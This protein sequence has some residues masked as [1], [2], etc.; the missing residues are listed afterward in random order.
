M[1]P[2][3]YKME[4]NRY[5][6][7]LIT[8]LFLPIIP[9]TVI[10]MDIDDYPIHLV[11]TIG[12]MI[13]WSIAVWLSREKMRK[14]MLAAIFALTIIPCLIEIGWFAIGKELLHNHQFWVIFDTNMQ[15]MTGFMQIVPV[16]AYLLS[17]AALVFLVFLLI[18]ALRKENAQQFA[19]KKSRI[20]LI[21]SISFLIIPIIIPAT[22]R[23]GYPINF[24]SSLKGYVV[25]LQKMNEFLTDRP[26]L[27]GKVHRTN[28]NDSNTVIVVIG[29][30]FNRNHSS[31]YGYERSTNPLLTQ[32]KDSLLIYKNVS[33]PD[34]FTQTCLNQFLTFP[35]SIKVVEN[36][37]KAPTLIEILK[38]AGFKTYWIDNQG[39]R[40]HSDTFFP[41]SYRLLASQSDYFFVN[42]NGLHDETLLPKLDSI[43]A[44]DTSKDKVIF[45]HLMGSHFPYKERVPSN[46]RL[47]FDS[48][49]TPSQFL[50][51]NEECDNYN[52]YDN[53][54][55]YNDSVV[56]QIFQRSFA[57]HGNHAVIYFADHGEEVYDN[58]RFAGRSNRYVS[59]NLYDVPFIVHLSKFYKSELVIHQENKARLLNKP[60]NTGY[61]AFTILHLCGITTA[62][63]WKK[64]SIFL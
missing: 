10:G 63:D 26:N 30:S 59:H 23:Y 36:T 12:V 40:G 21:A 1:L 34:Y 22:R 48:P 17:A 27:D 28:Y 52:M 42:P 7:L 53:S 58:F 4:K 8:S 57:L 3:Y 56:Y 13:C 61:L 35:D 60:Y 51:D 14:V 29:E 11:G 45:L 33:S 9:L 16:Y 38:S 5:S 41:T 25:D 32:I 64:Y 39:N 47:A 15:E 18:M 37:T 62:C 19:G 50:L 46:F 24:Y 20:F 49:E 31:L 54:I 2:L 6:V 43:L 44:N 55:V